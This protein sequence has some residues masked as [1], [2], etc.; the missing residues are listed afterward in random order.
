MGAV[1]VLVACEFSGVVRDAFRLAGHDAWSCDLLPT[2]REGP[3]IIEDVV[4]VLDR[5]WDLM[6][7]HPPCTR[8]ANSGVRWLKVPPVG[9]T[10]AEMWE[11]LEQACEL[12][13][14]LR[15]APIP[16]KAIENPVM[17]PYA[18]GRLGDIERQVVQPHWFG[19]PFF[20]ATGFELHG[21]PP[22]RRTH[23]MKLPKAGTAEHKKW[24]EVWMA[25]PGPERW[26]L[27]SRTK[28]GVAA[29][30]AAQWG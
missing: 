4:R 20:K 13:L 11:E 25:A 21:L 22:L 27:R 6:V 17:H 7:A 16:R 8:L 29:A 23:H 18:K 30:L 15:N 14:A 10:L 5:G 24:S 19:E 1:K 26:K 28:P 12:Y 9:R 2:D 3:H